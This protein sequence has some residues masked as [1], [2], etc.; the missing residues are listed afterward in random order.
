VRI[1]LDTNV[2]VSALLHPGRTSAEVLDLILE[3]RVTI[4]LEERIFAEYSGVLGRPKFKISPERRARVLNYLRRHGEHVLVA[5]IVEALPDPDDLPFLEAA[6]SG[7]ADA[8][9]TG[10]KRH[11][12]PARRRGI[13]VLS[14]SEFLELRKGRS[15]TDR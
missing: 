15:G 3:G 12:L 8:L 9:V 5:P 6:V 10:N 14:P 1:V 11:Y 13:A 4:V 7:S 2:L